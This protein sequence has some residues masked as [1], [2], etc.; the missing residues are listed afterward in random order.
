M[1]GPY[2]S[3]APAVFIDQAAK[4]GVPALIIS[5]TGNDDFGKMCCKKL[6]EDGADIQTSILLKGNKLSRKLF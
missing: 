4:F 3:G 5:T 1:S 2:A 6:E